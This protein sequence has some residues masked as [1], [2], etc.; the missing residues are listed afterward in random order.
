[1]SSPQ[2]VTDPVP[3]GHPILDTTVYLLD[4][5][6]K[7]VPPGEP[8]DLYTGGAGVARGYLNAAAETSRVFVADPAAPTTTTK[9][10]RTGDIARWRTDGKLE[11]MG[12]ADDQ[13]KINGH[14]IELGEVEAAMLSYPRIQQACALVVVGEHSGKRLVACFKPEPGATIPAVEY[15]SY[16]SSRLPSYLVPASL[17]QVSAI[18]MTHNGKVDRVELAKLW[19]IGEKP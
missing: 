17:K 6:M 18:P 12:R 19:K 8:G 15:R 5:E 9:M 10:Y 13:V 16:L 11:F 14:R 7:P 1:M 3:I 4:A 2:E